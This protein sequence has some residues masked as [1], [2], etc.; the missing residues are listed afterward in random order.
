MSIEDL[1]YRAQQGDGEAFAEICRQFDNLAKKYA[2][3]QHIRSIY[4]DALAEARLA[5]V[6]AVSTYDK[7]AGICFAAFAKN[8]VY[9]RLW[10]MFKR[11]RRRWQAEINRDS[12]NEQQ[13]FRE[14]TDQVDV[15]ED[16]IYG[17]MSQKIIRPTL[18]KALDALPVKQRQ[19]LLRTAVAGQKLREISQAMGI[20]VQAVHRLKYRALTNMRK[21]IAEIL[22]AEQESVTDLQK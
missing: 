16:I 12:T 6:E 8:K 14:I 20:S 5:I 11:E 2:Y 13:Y 7:S 4:S 9:Y 22:A 15:E 21:I 10:N 18:Y 3:Q 1:V 17:I 19:V